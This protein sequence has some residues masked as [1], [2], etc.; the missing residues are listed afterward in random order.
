MRANK[1]LRGFAWVMSFTILFVLALCGASVSLIVGDWILWKTGEVALA[2]TSGI[3]IFAGFLCSLGVSI[4]IWMWLKVPTAYDLKEKGPEK[5][6]AEV[7]SS[8]KD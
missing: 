3:F 5:F 2:W 1:F 4:G 7:V 6:L 8:E